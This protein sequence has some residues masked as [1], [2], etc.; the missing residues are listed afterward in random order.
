[1]NLNRRNFLR[2]AAGAVAV[3]TVSYFFAPVGGWKSDVIVHPKD[4]A[5]FEHV[6][7]AQELYKLNGKSV[8]YRGSRGGGKSELQRLLAE[9]D[10]LMFL[11]G[12]C[13]TYTRAVA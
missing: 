11:Y 7:V 6:T 4:P 13:V 12:N 2:L 8:L 10:R 9:R 1:M 3:P 5:S